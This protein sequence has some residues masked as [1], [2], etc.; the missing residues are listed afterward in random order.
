ML[1]RIDT[2]AKQKLIKQ[3]HLNHPVKQTSKVEN[4]GSLPNDITGMFYI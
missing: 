1:F 4:K 2:Y 3:K